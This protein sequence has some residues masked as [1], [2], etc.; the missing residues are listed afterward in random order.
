MAK[1]TG[2]ILMSNN[3]IV[4]LHK[5][6]INNHEELNKV[7]TA[8]CFSCVTEFST[9]KIQKW[10][11]AGKT[12]ICPNCKIDSVIP[13]TEQ[14]TTEILNEMK[15]FWFDNTLKLSENKENNIFPLIYSTE[16]IDSSNKN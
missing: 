11:D 12:A 9:K 14:T 13:K 7:K 4:D 3:P 15:K 2:D 10:E 16:E 1:N 8:V 5:L 6:S